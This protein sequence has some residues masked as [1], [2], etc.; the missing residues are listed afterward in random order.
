MSKAKKIIIGIASAAIILIYVICVNVYTTNCEQT[1]LDMSS[2]IDGQ[3]KV[4]ETMMDNAINTIV[5]NFKVNRMQA[6]DAIELAQAKAS[7][8]KGGLLFKSN[9][10]AASHFG[11]TPSTY[12]KMMNTIEGKLAGFKSAQDKLTSMWVEHKKFVLS[13]WHNGHWM[14]L[15]M[16]PHLASK[17]LPEPEMI[18]SQAVKEAQKTKTFDGTNLIN[19]E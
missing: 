13:P 18:S 1:E 19:I 14:H 8:R 16:G 2:A 3:P 4:I 17:L 9:T 5:N 11:V 6:K 15:G 7:G 10:E 12:G